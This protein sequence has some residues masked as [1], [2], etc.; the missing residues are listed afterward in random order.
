MINYYQIII[1]ILI[2]LILYNITI[3]E[4]L[5]NTKLVEPTIEQKV[6]DLSVLEKQ[7][8]KELEELS[9]ENQKVFFSPGNKHT[10]LQILTNF[11]TQQFIIG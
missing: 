4:S 9:S 6:L 10:K 3:R 11:Y 1:I 5:T 7:N 2:G 8:K